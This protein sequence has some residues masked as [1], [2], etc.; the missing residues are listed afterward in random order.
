MEA[1]IE[2]PLMTSNPVARTSGDGR[3]K[4]LDV[5]HQKQYEDQQQSLNSAKLDGDPWQMHEIQ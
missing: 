5:C 1:P 2:L 4:A 3:G